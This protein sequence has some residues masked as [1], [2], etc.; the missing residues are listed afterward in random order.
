MVDENAFEIGSSMPGHYGAPTTGLTFAETKLACVWNVQGDARVPR[1]VDAL[2]SLGV[3]T[4]PSVPNTTTKH[5]ALTVLWLGPK[6]WLLI[7]SDVAA[8]SGFDSRR[9]AL[10]AAGGALFDV[11]ASRAAWTIAGDA[12]ATVLAKGCPLDFHPRA[13]PDGSCAQSVYGHVNALFYRRVSAPVFTMFVARSFARNIWRTL[14]VSAAQYGYD[15]LPPR[16][17]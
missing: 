11:S 1:F 3:V 10:N 5:G 7:A 8:L 14:C 9:D 12:A 17:F 16:D 15:V 6:S 2:Q 4:L 13:F